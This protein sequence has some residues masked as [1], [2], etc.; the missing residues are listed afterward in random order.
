MDTG[1]MLYIATIDEK[2]PWVLTSE[3]VLLSRPLYGWENNSGTINNEGPYALILKEKVYLAYS[4]GA[5]CGYSYVIG[6][7]IADAKDNLLDVNKWMKFP[8]PVFHSGSVEGIQGPGH[9]SFF[10]D[11]EGRLMI[12]YHGQERE[13][14]FKRCSAI[15]PVHIAKDGF[16]LLNVAGEAVLPEAMR[17]ITAIIELHR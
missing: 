8:A 17:E 2:E 7:L 16:P 6:Y 9:N 12:A 3:P 5:A 14:Y 4:G 13:K 1:S 11:E 10:Y 15:H